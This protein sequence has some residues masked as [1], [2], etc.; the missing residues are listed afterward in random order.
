[1]GRTLKK[2]RLKR[3][4][5][6]T[7]LVFLCSYLVFLILWIQVKDY[8]G[9]MITLIASEGMSLIED[10]RF[11]GITTK[12]NMTQATFS[13][14]LRRRAEVLID[15]PIETSTYTFNVPLT[16]AIMAAFFPLIRRRWRAYAEALV[17]LL[18][19]HLLYVFSLEANNLTT[20]SISKGLFVVSKTRLIIY[21]FIW[22][23]TDNM[24]IRFIP[25][26]IGFYL[27]IRFRE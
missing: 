12:E 22:Q 16:F 10:V 18:G 15:V 3:I 9:Y 7:V 4:V 24:V 25:F 8:Y 21:Q 6:K 26:L 1:M 17:I 23:F 14:L 20:F 5:P 2:Q 19:V 11:E 27:F 13:R